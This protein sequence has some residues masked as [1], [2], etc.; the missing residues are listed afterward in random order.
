MRLKSS[1]N[2]ECSEI[3]ENQNERVKVVLEDE[4]TGK[5]RF[6]PFHILLS[7]KITEW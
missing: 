7:N 2:H 1:E 3:H 4:K 6:W 5:Y